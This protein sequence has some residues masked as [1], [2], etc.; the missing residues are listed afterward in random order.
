[1]FGLCVCLHTAVRLAGAEQA[2]DNTAADEATS[3]PAGSRAAAAAGGAR[4]KW[5]AG[6]GVKRER[7]NGDGDED[8]PIPRSATAAD[9]IDLTEEVRGL[10]RAGVTWLELVQCVLV[11]VFAC[12]MALLQA[13][14]R[15][16]E[17]EHHL[18]NMLQHASAARVGC[19]VAT[20]LLRTSPG[21]AAL[22]LLQP[23]CCSPC[24]P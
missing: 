16:R 12:S 21:P 3:R 23:H 2:P 6:A 22:L 9:R 15:C 4:V 24:A 19:W 8:E 17:A 5:E 7:Q 13:T 11:M 1:M 14:A 10:W 18:A 20:L